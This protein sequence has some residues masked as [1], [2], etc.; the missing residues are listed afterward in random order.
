MERREF[1]RKKSKGLIARICRGT[2]EN[3]FGPPMKVAV[4]DVSGGGL[5]IET[6]GGINV[7]DVVFGELNLMGNTI[8]FTGEVVRSSGRIYGIKFVAIREEDRR[9]LVKFAILPDRKA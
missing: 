4:R 7:G 6:D 5:G 1:Y 3:G 8:R 2:V 9:K